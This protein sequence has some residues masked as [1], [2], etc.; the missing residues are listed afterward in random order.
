MS[1]IAAVWHG[2]ILLQ[3][4][5]LALAVKPLQ[6]VAFRVI[7]RVGVHMTLLVESQS[8]THGSMKMLPKQ[9]PRG[10]QTGF[11][12]VHASGK[13][14]VFTHRF[15][16]QH[17]QMH[18]SMQVDEVVTIYQFIDVSKQKQMTVLCARNNNGPQ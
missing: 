2:G 18:G 17:I 15:K 1:P 13:N 9:D 16:V 4:T 5:H 14:C 6:T 8:N 12:G 10:K 11:P 7:P 3:P